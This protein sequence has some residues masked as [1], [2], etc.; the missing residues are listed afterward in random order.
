[1]TTSLQDAKGAAPAPGGD[2]WQQFYH[3]AA[4]KTL[5]APSQFA[6]FVLGEF[7]DINT[8]VDV[9]CGSGRD[10][11]FFARQGKRVVGVDGSASGVELC[12]SVAAQ[13]RLQDISFIHADVRDPKLLTA[14]RS[15]VRD[16]RAAVYARFFLHAITEDA[17]RAF[18]EL[19]TQTCGNGGM[20]AVEFRTK[21]DA[22]Q[23]KVTPDHFRRFL[24]PVDFLGRAQQCGLTLEY[25][26]EGFGYAKYK[27]DDAHVARCLFRV[28]TASA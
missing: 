13:N 4:A 7:G 20:I 21:R 22:Q 25:F 9:G 16:A 14:C 6:V 5:A 23:T 2:H 24:D 26:V 17:E 3:S 27:Q 8:V 28:G 19:A 18:L 11:L 1:M 10:S 15:F 12:R